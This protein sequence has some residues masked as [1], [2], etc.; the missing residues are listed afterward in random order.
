M[1]IFAFTLF[2]L[3]SLSGSAQP[4][5]Q[6]LSA[7]NGE[8][9]NISVQK[10]NGDSLST[11]FLIEVKNHVPKHYHANHTEHVYIL[12]G[13]GKFLLNADTFDVKPG[14][15]LFI[16]MQ[17]IHEVWVDGSE[18]MRVLSIQSPKFLGND[19]VLVD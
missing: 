2:C 10:L 8:E 15:Y 4:P 7:G 17:S 19:R 13:S 14:D 3:I 5:I 6:I 12:H 11:S 1:K 18:P 9:K 16:P